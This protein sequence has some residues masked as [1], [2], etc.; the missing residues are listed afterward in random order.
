MALNMEF[1]FE[2]IKLGSVGILSGIFSVAIA[3]GGIATKNGGKCESMLIE[4]ELK[5]FQI[6]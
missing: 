5:H 2:L 4:V 1:F 3:L 6:S